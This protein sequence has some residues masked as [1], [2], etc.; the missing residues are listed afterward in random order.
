M[1]EAKIRS[2]RISMEHARVSALQA[3]ATHDAAER[4]W[5]EGAIGLLREE[6]EVNRLACDIRFIRAR[7][8]ELE[9][10]LA[11]ARKRI[12]GQEVAA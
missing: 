1:P 12:R 2:A 7:T 5:A 8:P 6:W 10:A 9:E 11:A 4:L 3:L